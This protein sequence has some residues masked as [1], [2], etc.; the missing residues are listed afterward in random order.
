MTIYQIISVLFFITT[1]VLFL[2]LIKKSKK[3]QAVELVLSNQA[4]NDTSNTNNDESSLANFIVNDEHG[5][6][7]ITAHEIYKLPKNTLEIETAK[8]NR[9]F[10]SHLLADVT[11]SGISVPNKTIELAFKT[12]IQQGLDSGDYMMMTTKNNEV[13]ADAINSKTKKLVGKGRVIQG[14]KLKQCIA[15]AFQVAS[16][17]VAQAHLAEISQSLKEIHSSLDDIKDRLDIM[18]T[19]KIKGAI[20][21][22]EKVVGMIRDNNTPDSLDPAIATNL[23]GCIKESHQSV[24]SILSRFE[25]LIKNIKAFEAVDTFGTKDTYSALKKLA[26]QMEDIGKDY[27]LLLQLEVISVSLLGYLDPKG[28][29]FTRMDLKQE[30]FENLIQQYLDVCNVKAKEQFFDTGSKFNERNTLE[31]RREN[32]CHKASLT[33]NELLNDLKIKQTQKLEIEKQLAFF[34]D[35]EIRMGITFDAN[36]DVQRSAL[37]V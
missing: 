29:K 21:Y 2:F 33:S 9:P 10:V 12:D 34:E 13:L 19:S 27:S 22:F 3:L 7:V 32:I 25:S 23:E 20:T 30:S 11:K 37:L 6:S 26:L 8:S 5:E 17:V 36:G 4:P 31:T 24:H 35:D 18:E 1:S 15:G 14:G 16:I 28:T